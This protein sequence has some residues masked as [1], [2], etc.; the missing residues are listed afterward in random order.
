MSEIAAIGHNIPP[1]PIEALRTDL[2]EANH[3]LLTRKAELEASCERMPESIGDD[4]TA[5]KF[6]DQIK[7]LNTAKKTAEAR[8]KDTKEPHLA[9]SRAVDAFFKAITE[10]LEKLAAQANA[11]L[12]AFEQHKADEE[13]RRREEAERLAREEAERQVREAAV[14]SESIETEA[15]LDAAIRV[16]EGADQAVAAARD[17][18]QDA[19]ASNAELSRDRGNYGAVASLRTTWAGEITALPALDLETLRPHISRDALDKALRAFIKAGGRKLTGAHI[20]EETK[21]V[22]R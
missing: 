21:T 6:A 17:A 8:R 1:D 7:L 15:D 18:R 2:E 10:P 12:T 19:E 4:E 5:G 3:D 9:A 13:R 20:F 16:E 11:P 14:A 22:V